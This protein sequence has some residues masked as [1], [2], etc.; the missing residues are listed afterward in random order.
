MRNAQDEVGFR[1]LVAQI[2]P[3]RTLLAAAVVLMLGQSAASLLVPRLAGQFTNGVL[4]GAESGKV[5]LLWLCVVA[6]QSALTFASGY[7]LSR[8]GA[9]I[10]ARLS[11]RLY[12][13]LQAMPLAWFHE[14]KR[15]AVLALLT[16]DV[17]RISTFVTGTLVRLLPQLVTFFGALVLIY[18]VDPP[19]AVAVLVFLP[20]FF[21]LLKVATRSLRPLSDRLARTQAGQVAIAE[22]NFLLLPVIKSF[23]REDVESERF[24]GQTQRVLSLQREQHLT[25]QLLSPVVRILLTAALVALL[26]LGSDSLMSGAMAPGDLVSLLLYGMLMSLPLASLA[27]I[28]GEIQT[29][30]G[31]ATRLL[32]VF[33]VSPE[34]YQENKPA[35][36]AIRGEV[37]FEDVCFRYPGRGKLLDGLSLCVQAG[38]T[39]A[40]TGANGVGKSTLAHMLLRLIEPH[41]GR[42][43]IDGIDIGEVELTSLRRQVGLVDQNTLLLNGTVAENIG[44]GRVDASAEVLEKA[45]RSADAHAFIAGLPDGYET[46]IG[47]Q[48]VKL[49]GGQKQRIALARALLKD[50]AILMLDEATSMFDPEGERALVGECR[51]ALGSR[52]VILITHRPESLKLA[53]RVYRLEAGAKRLVEV[54]RA[55]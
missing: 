10:L 9:E 7:L 38:E 43:T 35:M 28:Y 37:R 48:G 8:A 17:Q 12:D 25:V 5:L 16:N 24:R 41:Q 1:F 23:V 46:L 49:S 15:G 6:V 31:A 30:G 53:D 39:I 20:L 19:I 2:N 21:V 36:H 52:T 18:L 33:A 3:Q 13:H 27:N 44:Y 26:W 14:R 55:S 32:D 29:A 51:D 42:I 11:V 45:A 40:L 47:D 22:Q 4:E 54:R 50:P 34:P